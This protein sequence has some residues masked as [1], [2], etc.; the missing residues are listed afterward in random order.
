MR[1]GPQEGTGSHLA[2]T[3]VVAVVLVA[4]VLGFMGLLGVEVVRSVRYAAQLQRLSTPVGGTRTPV[5][6]AGSRAS[7]RGRAEGSG[8]GGGGGTGDVIAT[9]T[10]SRLFLKESAKLGRSGSSGSGSGSSS[11]SGGGTSGNSGGGATAGG[12][13][14]AEDAKDEPPVFGGGSSPMP[15]AGGVHS[16]RSAW[17]RMAAPGSLPGRGAVGGGVGSRGGA[18]VAAPPGAV[19]AGDGIDG[20]DSGAQVVV[21]ANPVSAARLAASRDKGSHL[22]G[23]GA[24]GGGPSSDGQ[25]L[26]DN[27]MLSSMKR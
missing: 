13:S 25:F 10:Q 2:L 9:L 5:A 16:A 1:A 15:A 12:R 14:S 19:G 8:D 7:G 6:S 26:W 20:G 4:C 18:G 17:P 24:G 23:V 27:P 22:G 21:V 11:G 3:Y